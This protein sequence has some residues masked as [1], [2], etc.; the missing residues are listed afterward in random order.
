M[1]SR[2]G[3]PLTP[4]PAVCRLHLHSARGRRG[5]PAWPAPSPDVRSPDTGALGVRSLKTPTPQSQAERST[6]TASPAAGV[7]GP[8][9]QAPRCPSPLP[10][11][12][13]AHPQNTKEKNVTEK[14][15]TRQQN[16]PLLM[17]TK[18]AE[19]QPQL[20]CAESVIITQPGV[21]ASLSG[22]SRRDGA[23]KAGVTVISYCLTIK[24]QG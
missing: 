3:L 6:S 20:L 13:T 2:A 15:A 22:R 19:R 4:P 8:G 14:P 23:R 11:L 18:L 17:A 16:K 24:S 5:A 12:A 7:P 9:T 21:K 1:T 10:A